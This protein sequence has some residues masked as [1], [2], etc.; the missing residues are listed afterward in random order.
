[1]TCALMF[2]AARLAQW[3]I[4]EIPGKWR[5]RR[6]LEATAERIALPEQ[7]LVRIADGNRLSLNATE[8]LDRQ[9]YLFGSWEDH[10]GAVLDRILRPG[11]VFVDVGGNIGYHALHAA[12]LVGPSGRVLAFKPNPTVCERLLANTALNRFDHV[13]VRAV[14][15]SDQCGEARF[16]PDSGRNSGAGSLRPSPASGAPF[17][18]ATATLDSV[19]ETA[20]IR[21][22]A[23]VKIDVEGA[24]LLVLS[25]MKW[26]LGSADAPAVIFEISEWSLAQ[27]GHSGK[28]IMNLMSSYGYD[29]TVIS[30]VRQSIYATEGQF[31]QYDALF[32]RAR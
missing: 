9:I 21:R 8:F 19:L 25:G 27:F 1:M 15:L 31:L 30:P 10:V 32:Q 11:D 7:A 4:P 24:E 29:H 23:V 2:H 28:N 17:D 3:R 22:V 16:Y 26:L 13:E 20:G 18:V 5:L 14:A 6:Y 12:R